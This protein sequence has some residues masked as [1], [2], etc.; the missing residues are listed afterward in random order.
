MR[1][2]VVISGA[3]TPFLRSGTGYNDLMS[4]QLGQYAIR[5]LLQL[6]GDLFREKGLADREVGHLIPID[7]VYEVLHSSLGVDMQ[8]TI[9]RAIEFCK[10]QGN[11]LAERVVKAVA[12]LEMVQDE[13]DNKTTAELIARCL[14]QQ[15]GQTNQ[16]PEVQAALDLL[17]GHSFLALSEK[18]GYKIE[19]AAGQEWQNERDKYTPSSEQASAEVRELLKTM[20]G[21]VEIP[22]IDTLPLPWLVLFS[23]G[24]GSK[25]L[26]LKD[27]RK[28]TVLTV[29]FQFATGEA[30]DHWI[31]RSASEAYASRFI[32][33]VGDI[34]DVKLAATKLVQCKRMILNHRANENSADPERRNLLIEERNRVASLE[35]ALTEAIKVAFMNGK[36][37]F[38]GRETSPV[39]F[40]N[41]FLRALAGFGSSIARTLYPNPLTFSISEKD[42]LSLIENR[43]LAAPP[44]VLTADK[45]GILT[46]DAG[47]WEAS[48]SGRL[49]SEVLAL[50]RERE[51]VEGATLLAHFGVP[52]H[53]VAP[54]LV[55]AVVVGLL[56]GGKLR[57][58]IPG[59]GD[60]TSV[61]DQGVRELLKETVLRKATLRVNN[62]D[63]LT[64]RDR[65]GICGVLENAFGQPVPRD[66]DAIADAVT[67]RF[68]TVRE[69]LNDIGERFRK[70]RG[71]DYPEALTKLERALEACRRVRQ[72]EPMLKAVQANLGALR[73]GFDWLRRTET[74]LS[75][76]AIKT[77]Q[78]ANTLRQF[79]AAQLSAL[80]PSDAVRDAIARVEAQFKQSRPWEGAAELE[81]ALE[82]LQ[83]EYK[84]R[85]SAII[86]AHEQR[87]DQLRTELKMRHGFDTLDV[88]Q[89]DGVL[90]PLRDE[91]LIKVDAEA[92]EPPLEALG[93]VLRERLEQ[94][95][96]RALQQ[97]D[98]TLERAGGAPTVDVALDFRGREIKSEPELERFL[99][100]LR[101][102]ILH[103]LSAKHHVRLK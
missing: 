14:Y 67:Q 95:W 43:D 6:L 69:R 70:L 92:I 57:V 32:W 83:R 26:R 45:L 74:D 86:H 87:L 53:G 7:L 29:D 90:A 37:F 42:V 99:E 24:Y 31:P 73:D 65:V 63:P 13:R 39:D 82:L 71:V 50:I 85:R 66:N 101:R 88:D 55:R 33:L 30:P 91:R 2:V 100:E 89:R 77:L 81:P 98:A 78:D 12:M 16:E 68:A 38:R 51:G 96:T 20:L 46:Q 58:E 34:T 40:G 18:K 8:V 9:S 11:K 62:Q 17:L 97:L 1:K 72:V 79:Q 103:E 15:L 80:T 76:S 5:G 94:G 44:A 75:E 23:D 56:R 60:L 61:Q 25:D 49:P 27:E 52:P 54:D 4:Y 21:D 47:R 10:K 48:C 41:S 84:A 28:H 102:K 35:Q 93:P 36:L 22:K 3:R 19:S 59:L 64:N